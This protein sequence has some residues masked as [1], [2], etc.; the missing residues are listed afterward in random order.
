MAPWEV[1]LQEARE[2]LA[3]QE[4]DI[5]DTVAAARYSADSSIAAAKE[6]LRAEAEQSVAEA[7][8]R[9][10]QDPGPSRESFDQARERLRRSAAESIEEAQARLRKEDEQM[11]RT[12]REVV[13]RYANRGYA[14]PGEYVTDAELEDV[15]KGL[16]RRFGRY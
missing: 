8:A 7:Q 6:R 13:Q 16:E 9:L 2:R 12:A 1:S 5:S 3:Q 4:R 10:R 14:R 15:F 11:L